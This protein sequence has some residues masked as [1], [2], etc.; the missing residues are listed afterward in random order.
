MVKFYE[1]TFYKKKNI[2]KNARGF[3]YLKVKNMSRI[4]TERPKKFEN[5]NFLK[6]LF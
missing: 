3:K 6:P 5:L 1:N 2:K 4:K